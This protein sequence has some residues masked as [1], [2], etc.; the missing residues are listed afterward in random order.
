MFSVKV[1]RSGNGEVEYRAEH[2]SGI[3]CRISPERINRR[4]DA[5]YTPPAQKAPCPFC[6]GSLEEMTPCFPDGHRIRIGESVTFPN[7]FPYAEHHSV[8][9]ITRDHQVGEFGQGQL[10]DALCGQ[11]ISLLPFKGYPSLNWNYLPSA[12]ASIAHPH[13]QGIVDP[14]PSALA[15]RYIRGSHRYL[16]RKGRSYREDLVDRECREGRFLFGD[17]IS[18]LAQAVPLGER[19]VRAILPVSCMPEFEPYLDTFAEGLVAVLAM[20]RSLGTHAFNMSIFFDRPGASRGFSAFC[21][22]ISRINPNPSSLSDTAFMERL[23]QEPVILT[24]P[25]DLAA[26]YRKWRDQ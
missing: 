13:M 24:L 4:L 14:R 22:I 21:S 26:Y 12:G 8:T 5:A 2:I 10:R 7:L 11:L 15:M 3:R 18:W 1:A 19:E 16:R 6:P 9:V 23:H 17:E 20:Y 25:E